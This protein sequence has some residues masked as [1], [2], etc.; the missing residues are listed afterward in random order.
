MKIT[1]FIIIFLAMIGSLPVG[2]KARPKMDQLELQE[3]IQRFHS[4]FTERVVQAFIDPHFNTSPQIREISLN[5]YLL[6]ESESL[7]IATGPYPELNLLDM[8]VFIKLNKV[9]VRDYW[10]PKKYGKKGQRVWMAF[11]K[12]EDDIEGIAKKLLSDKELKQIDRLV[13][14]W[15]KKNP[16]QYRVEKIRV[17]DFSNIASEVSKSREGS[18]WNLSSFSVSHLLVDT[19]GAVKA[20][21]QI[22]LV[23]NRAIF[24]VQHLPSLVRLQARIGAFEIM[25]DVS[26][27][28][29]KSEG[30]W[31]KL[32]ETK[33]LMN[34][35]SGLLFQMNE[36]I[37]NAKGLSSSM[38]KTV[39]KGI[40]WSDDLKEIH[41]TV[42]TLNSMLTEVN[43]TIPARRA[44]LQDV[45]NEIHSSIWF[46][47]LVI[48][49]IALCISV[50]WWGGAYLVK[51]RL[52]KT[53]DRL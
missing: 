48:V 37:M 15:F 29:A 38:Q 10:I 8:L 51:R 23:S 44:F 30:V 39:P 14:E 18:W 11:K 42:D 22:V 41:D 53:E 31:N 26:Y 35:A 34:D 46:I 1:F 24:L 9:V 43:T 17:G 20:V 21:D 50:F 27:K 16:G 47:A 13:I 45:K 7:K 32:N 25:D 40:N 6:Y 3:D 2:A 5:E 4:R 33:P 19:K 52:Q 49:L 28:M 12:S 36:L